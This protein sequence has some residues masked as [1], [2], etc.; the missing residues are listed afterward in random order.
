MSKNVRSCGA[1]HISKS[2]CTKHTRFGALFEVKMSKKCMPLLR[3]AHFEV[4]MYKAE[5][6]GDFLD[7]GFAWPGQGIVHRV[8]NEQ[9]V[10]VL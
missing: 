4:K 9:K 8:I 3:Q 7:G 1:K 2:K 5:G 6:L 10:R